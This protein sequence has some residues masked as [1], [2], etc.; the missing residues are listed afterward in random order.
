VAAQDQRVAAVVSQC[1]FTDGVATLLALG[2]TASLRLTVHG[3]RDQAAALTGGAP[4][5]IPAVGPPGSLAVMTKPDAEPG[6][7]ALVPP[8]SVWENRVA[9]RIALRV[10]LYRPGLAA[11]RIAAPVLGCVC[12]RDSLAPAERTVALISR[13][14]QAQIERYPIGH[15]DIYVGEDFERAVTD[16]VAFLTRHLSP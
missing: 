3:L 13:A 15:F 6:M 12:D 1:P 8:D 9:A 4:H 14:P 10:A 7:R 16:M 2:A 11:A 5:Y